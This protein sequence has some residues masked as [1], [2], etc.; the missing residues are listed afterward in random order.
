MNKEWV[1][2]LK[3]FHGIIH[4]GVDYIANREL[5][6]LMDEIYILLQKER[7]M[8]HNNKEWEREIESFFCERCRKDEEHPE[9]D[10]QN[11]GCMGLIGLIR[12]ILQ[13][14]RKKARK[15]GYKEARSWNCEELTVDNVLATIDKIKS[16]ARKEERQSI[17]E[18]IEGIVK[19]YKIFNPTCGYES[20][21][22]KGYQK[23]MTAGEKL[24]QE[25]LI[26]T[27]NKIK[28]F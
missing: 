11:S 2:I 12:K 5:H 7:Q 1:K 27:I 9:C 13:K 16:E 14:E 3:K 25:D 21:E 17:C 18:E 22:E 26:V 4:Y 23:G 28:N 20:E 24:M 8:T 15:Q 19:K 6:D 10:F